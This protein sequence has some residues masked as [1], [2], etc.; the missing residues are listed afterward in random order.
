MQSAEEQNHNEKQEQEQ[1]QQQEQPMNL[2][3]PSNHLELTADH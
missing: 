1:E 2:A 3:W